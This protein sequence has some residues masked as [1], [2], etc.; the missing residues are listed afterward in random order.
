MRLL[1][2][3]TLYFLVAMVAVLVT[4][5][6]FLF[7]QF[8]RQ[9]DQQTDQELLLEE[10][11]WIRYLRGQVDIGN[12]FL[13]RTPDIII[14]PTEETVTTYPTISQLRGIS[15]RQ[16]KEVPYRQLLHMVAINGVAY[17]IIIRRSQEQKL[18]FVSNI[19][20][21]MLGVFVGM[22]VA[23]LLVNWF[24]NQN[25]WK[26]FRRSLQK[27]RAAEL[28]KMQA[29]RFDKSDITEFNDLNTS[30]N[31]MTSRIY[32]DY[33][34][35]KEFTENAAHE[36]Q[37]PLAV[38]QSKLEI[39][40]QDVAITNQQA[41]AIA[42]AQ[43]ALQRLVN[44]NQSLLMMAK[45][46]NRQ[47]QFSKP[48]VLNSVVEKYLQLFDEI[49]KAKQLTVHV[50]NA[51]AFQVN[52]HLVLVESLVSNLLGNAIKYNY[53]GGKVFIT[54]LK[55]EFTI[56]NTSTKPALPEGKEFKRFQQSEAANETS[57][58]LGL[59]IVKK[60]TDTHQLVIAY[61]FKQGTHSFSVKNK[62]TP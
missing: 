56:S 60:I 61:V 9:L 7:S 52:M 35:M 11:Q 51:E 59:A 53:Q 41:A 23:I 15:P 54:L 25:I 48:V 26:P 40:L 45:I 57:N 62:A 5:G 24:I 55:N 3:T 47:Y 21:I 30:L 1:T 12:A 19:T 31:Y 13:L 33:M 20:R 58:G 39:L 6:Y 4:A 46:D 34:V 42:N 14:F 18:V 38:V 49:F 29:V 16:N 32:N 8:S 27:I 2:K 37:T 10:V 22:L 44:L 36:M 50:N 43:T 17:Q 28:Q